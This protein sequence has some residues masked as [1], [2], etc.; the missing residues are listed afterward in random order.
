MCDFVIGGPYV[1]LEDYLSTCSTGNAISLALAD[2]A[3]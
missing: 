1:S 3:H 2:T